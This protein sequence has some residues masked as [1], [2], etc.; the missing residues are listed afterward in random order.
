[1]NRQEAEQFRQ[2]IQ[3]DRLRMEAKLA[4]LIEPIKLYSP[5]EGDGGP[6]AVCG[7]EEPFGNVTEDGKPICFG[8][9]DQW[10]EN[11]HGDAFCKFAGAIATVR[12]ADLALDYCR[13]PDSAIHR[14][15]AG[16]VHERLA[17]LR[18]GPGDRG[19]A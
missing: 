1:M 14:R 5:G 11:N 4:A 8:C 15:I 13:D 17:E 10:L 3:Q 19:R 9:I 16:E 7:I 12:E 2:Q 6:C 18:A